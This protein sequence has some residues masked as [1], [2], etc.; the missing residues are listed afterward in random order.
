MRT[1]VDRAHARYRDLAEGKN[2]VN[3]ALAK[4]PAGLFGLSVTTVAG[5][6]VAAGDVEHSFSIQSISKICTL[7]LVLAQSGEQMIEESVGVNATGR[8]YNSLEAVELHQGRNMNP[9][10]TPGAIATT[11]NVKGTGPEDVWSKILGMHSAFT[12]RTLTVDEEVYRTSSSIN[13]RN[14]AAAMLM[15]SYGRFPG[16]PASVLDIYTRQCS[17]SVTATDLGVMA[18]TLANRGR[19]PRT[20][21]QVIDPVHVPGILAIMATAG[22]YDATG[23]WLFHTGLPAKSGVG[24]GLIAVAP[25]K[26]GIASFSPPLD[27]AGNSVRGQRAIA[28]ISKAIGGNPYDA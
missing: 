17:I 5:K 27:E 28:D 2:A 25:G 15:S 23:R 21:T 24:G 6:V 9:L 12:G 3:P 4:V 7:A 18:A 11:G 14:R 20:G 13:Q 8:A 16:D 22:L 10:V 26:Y 1:A 19:N